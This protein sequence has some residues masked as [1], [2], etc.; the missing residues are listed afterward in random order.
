M[1]S[2]TGE[3]EEEDPGSGGGVLRG[4]WEKGREVLLSNNCVSFRWRVKR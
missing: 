3:R 2:V 1:R 4:V